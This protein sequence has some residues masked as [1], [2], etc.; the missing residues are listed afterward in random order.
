LS[1]IG[2]YFLTAILL[3]A[4]AGLSAAVKYPGYKGPVNDLAGVLSPDDIQKLDAKII[5][6]RD[7][8]G[9][10]IGILIVPTLDGQSIE[11][12]A[13]DVFKEWGIGQKGKDNGVL[14]LVAIAEKKARIEV[15]YGL[16]GQLTDLESGRLVGRN[17]PMAEHFRAGDYPGGVE[18]V[19][20]GIIQ[21]I[22][23]DYNPPKRKTGHSVDIPHFLGIGIAIFILLMMIFRRD[24]ITR[25]RFGGPFG[26]GFFGGGFG[27]GS[28]SG[29]GGG[30]SF[31]GRS[32][33]GGGASGGW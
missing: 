24:K 28:S 27:G 12:Y 13:H 22:G 26:G 9:N 23:G 3:L 21:A 18:A 19:L 11:D 25:R 29:G 2:P 7:S 17:S 20:N 6:Y 14:F 10:E 15:G 32:S 31:G 1:R 4:A 33:G 8:T 5:H 16:E 30:F